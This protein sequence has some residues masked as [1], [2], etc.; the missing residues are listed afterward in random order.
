MKMSRLN[1]LQYIHPVTG[2]NINHTICQKFTKYYSLLV[3]SELVWL[4]LYPVSGCSVHQI[5]YFL[6]LAEA[7]LRLARIAIVRSGPTPNTATDSMETWFLACPRNRLSIKAKLSE[8]F[9]SHVWNVVVLD[10][11]TLCCFATLSI[12]FLQSY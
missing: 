8:L 9:R 11:R 7:N 2:Y 1:A 5:R 6:L 12:S 10:G 3:F 4:T